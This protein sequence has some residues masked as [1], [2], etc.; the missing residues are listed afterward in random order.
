MPIVTLAEAKAHLAINDDADD[1]LIDGKIAAAQAHLERWLGYE[2]ADEHETPPAD[3][4]EAVLALT[5]HFYENRE[6]SVV[7][8]SAALMPFSVREIIA[9]R[10]KWSC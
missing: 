6:A 5:A 1:L 8:V 2:I 4:K 10:R 3:L 7:G 9:G